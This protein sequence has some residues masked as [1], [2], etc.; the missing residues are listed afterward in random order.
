MELFARGYTART[1]GK[2]MLEEFAVV[3]ADS[4]ILQGAVL[5]ADDI[6]TYR[7][8]IGKLAVNTGLARKEERLRRLS[9]LAESWEEPA[10]ENTKAAGVY[11]KT[12][13]QIKEETDPLGHIVPVDKDDTW[14]QLLQQ[15]VSGTRP[16]QTP[17]LQD[18]VKNPLETSSPSVESTQSPT[19]SGTSSLGTEDS[20]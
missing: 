9:E 4:T 6:E 11:L 20:S 12:L 5:Y 13:D 2:F 15:L 16:S 14:L 10:K 8:E 7:K 3:I 1:I 19:N 17:Q 18:Q